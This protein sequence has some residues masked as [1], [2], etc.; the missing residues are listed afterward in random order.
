M[1]TLQVH[2]YGPEDKILLEEAAIPEPSAGQVRIRVHACGI[3]F[4][5][6]LLARGGYQVRPQAPFVPGSEF[7]GVVD[8][9][10]ECADGRLVVG[11]RV[12]GT[13]MG[14]WSEY[15]CIPQ[16]LA[17]PLPPD[18]DLVEASVVVAPYV[19]SLYAL[20]SRGS[21]AQGETLLV[22]GA[23][24]SVGHAAVQIG[25]V[26][27]ARVIA[28]VSSD[29]KKPI[30]RSAGADAV[31]RID[32]DWKSAVKALAGP[33]GVDVVYDPVGGHA[34]DTAFRTLG[35]GGRHLMVGFASGDIGAVKSNLCI[36]KGASL[37][38]VDARQAGERTPALMG[39]LRSEVLSLYRQGRIRPVIRHVLP[40]ERFDE[41]VE[42][43]KNR[44]GVGRVIFTFPADTQQRQP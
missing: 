21:L 16:D 41:A 11:M 2:G 14:A 37:V 43:M 23:T 32:E 3:S 19:T 40:V 4:V 39:E 15:I 33:S 20:K 1:K 5:D 6:L 29:E 31:V 13:R 42:C 10:G 12:C 27:G 8:A 38:G 36:V 35:W 22:L 17:C 26:L 9:L 7:S 34:T 28:V 25:K 30:I 18:A 24:G 44:T